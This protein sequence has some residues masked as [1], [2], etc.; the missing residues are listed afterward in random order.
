MP[1]TSPTNTASTG[2][3]DGFVT[4]ARVGSIPPGQGE[5]FTVG[6]RLVAVFN[7]GGTY[8]AIDDL[9]PHMGASLGAGPIE[10][11]VVT[12]PW[13]AW[14]FRLSDGAW[15]DNPRLA[16]DTFEVRVQGNEIQV[17]VPNDD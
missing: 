14:R 16:V 15:C 3:T 5:T 13:H 11:G 7:D 17:R 12:C 4:V 2:E 8:R 10:G 6:D 1:N 9:C